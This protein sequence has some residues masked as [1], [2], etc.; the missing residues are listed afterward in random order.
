MTDRRQRRQYYRIRYPWVE[1]PELL[2][3][4]HNFPL[5]DCSES[6]LRFLADHVKFAVGQA[7]RGVIRFRTG[8]LAPVEGSV[9][10]CRDGHVALALDPPGLPFAFV[11][12]DQQRLRALYPAWPP[13]DGPEFSSSDAETSSDA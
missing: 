2:V 10:W 13:P 6:G 7:V 12:S 11:L 9:V 4:E 1:R 8:K 3:G 5:V